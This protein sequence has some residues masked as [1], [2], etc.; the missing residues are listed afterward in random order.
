MVCYTTAGNF[1]PIDN[2]SFK[3]IHS[4][5]RMLTPKFGTLE[6]LLGRPENELFYFLTAIFFRF[7][8]N[9]E[10]NDYVLKRNILRFYFSTVPLTINTQTK[11]L[12]NPYCE[13]APVSPKEYT[14]F[15][16]FELYKTDFSFISETSS[17]WRPDRTIAIA[18][19]VISATSLA[20][21]PAHSLVSSHR[22]RSY[23]CE[24]MARVGRGIFSLYR[25]L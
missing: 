7:Y 22:K 9:S 23:S 10:K 19:R 1:V 18:R 11:R 20:R 3:F 5:W 13:P 16:Y 24:W 6:S 2:T 25:R 17:Q 8:W 4:R 15:L 14:I 12:A 21:T